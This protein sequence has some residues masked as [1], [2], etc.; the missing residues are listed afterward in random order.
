[1]ASEY[2]RLRDKAREDFRKA[3]PELLRQYVAKHPEIEAGLEK[4]YLDERSEVRAKNQ[5]SLILEIKNMNVTDRYFIEDG[6][7]VSQRSVM[8]SYRT[9][10]PP[11]TLIFEEFAQES[12]IEV[13]DKLAEKLKESGL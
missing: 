9:Y 10:S 7:I 2:L 11:K 12:P 4:H 8:T 1:M 6:N 3:L 5:A 13:L